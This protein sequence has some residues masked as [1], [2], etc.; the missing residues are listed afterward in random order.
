MDSVLVLFEQYKL[1]TVFLTV[2]AAT[3]GVPV[4][5]LP[6][7]L[8]A[9]A[10]AAHSG[11]YGAEALAMA[12]LASA[13]SG[14]IWFAA[15]RRLGRRVLALLC[16]IS[17][18]PDTCVRQNE[19]SFARRGATTLL[20][21]KF[22]PGLSVIA[23]PLAGAIGMSVWPFLF[24][25]TVGAALW[26]ACCIAAGVIFHAQI[27]ELLLALSNLGNAALLVG[28]V[29]LALYIAWRYW[30]RWLAIRSL[31][32]L[33][34]IEPHDLAALLERGEPVAILDVR[35]LA[36]RATQSPRIP[37]SHNVEL[38]HLETTP[39]ETWP[40]DGEIVAYCD[41][42]NDASAAK[43]AQILE[44]RGRRTRVLTGGLEGWAKAGFPVV[45]L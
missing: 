1:L 14:A 22:V 10:E 6:L 19:L 35:G 8:L 39:L 13:L 25:T 20:I 11:A 29:L 38:A 3:L 37:G 5:A 15:G 33:D 42:P 2:F 28:A 16:R 44:R 9:G 21:A 36:S 23:P 41:C 7:L 45:T 32:R 34:H 27:R 17:I 40:A 24:F 12:T 30:R 18:S 4:P 43:A 31:A 26:A